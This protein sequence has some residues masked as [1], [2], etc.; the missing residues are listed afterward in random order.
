MCGLVYMLHVIHPHCQYVFIIAQRARN[1]I[2]YMKLMEQW[3]LG[4]KICHT[5]SLGI[6]QKSNC[7]V[8]LMLTAPTCVCCN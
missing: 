4:C 3:Q 7:T 1:N 6:Y 8:V 2:Y 5:I